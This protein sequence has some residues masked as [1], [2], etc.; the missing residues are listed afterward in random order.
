MEL[1]PVALIP[2]LDDMTYQPVDVAGHAYKSF[3]GGLSDLAPYDLS[4]RDRGTDSMLTGQ[5]FPFNTYLGC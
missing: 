5:T 4:D 3:S 2:E 1:G